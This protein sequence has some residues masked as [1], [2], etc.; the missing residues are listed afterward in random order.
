MSS[1]PEKEVS[2]GT[3]LPISQSSIVSKDSPNEKLSV[4]DVGE[5]PIRPVTTGRSI[6]QQWNRPRINLWRFLTTLFN[7][8]MM[9]LNDGSFGV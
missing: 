8:L 1:S 7:F 2:L 5:E 6:L 9:G 3:P 4:A